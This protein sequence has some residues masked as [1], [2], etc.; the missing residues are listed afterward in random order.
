MLI[1]PPSGYCKHP[2][3]VRGQ[4]GIT[5]KFVKEAGLHRDPGDWCDD[6]F[7]PNKRKPIELEINPLNNHWL[8]QQAKRFLKKKEP[9]SLYLVQLIEQAKTMWAEMSDNM[10]QKVT[11]LCM[12]EELEVMTV[13][14]DMFPKTYGTSKEFLNEIAVEIKNRLLIGM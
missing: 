9:F 2:E 13:F 6:L 10:I 11:D 4:Y 5:E 3:N 14:K 7:E 8:N 1:G 12:M